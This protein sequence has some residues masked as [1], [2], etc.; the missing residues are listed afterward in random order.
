MLKFLANISLRSK[1]ERDNLQQQKRSLS[2][3]KI[4]KIA[5]VIDKHDLINKSA[6]DKFVEDTHKYIEV[7]YI[8]LQSKTATYS[9]WHCFSK[10]DKSL[11]N[12]PEKKLISELK[13]KK[14]DVVIN[15]CQETNLFAIAISSSFSSAMQC[16]C[17]GTFNNTN[18][19]IK[20]TENTNLLSY[21]A[22]VIKY[23]KM[24]RV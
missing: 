19:I 20:K 21:L 8:E 14:F 13:K 2:W 17:H 5:L 18:L 4:E 6:M 1:I 11:L 16:D 23:L 9:D 7:F 10:K 22:E 24:I 15:T 12:L 3:N